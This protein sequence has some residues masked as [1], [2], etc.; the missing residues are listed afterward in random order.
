MLGVWLENE[1]VRVRSDLPD[2]EPS[3][4][5]ALIR[6][7]RAGICGTD[8]ALARGYRPGRGRVPGHEFVGVVA[9]G[10]PEWIAARVVGEINVTCR[11]LAHGAPPC[12]ECASGRRTH[13]RR[14]AAVGIYG[15]DGAFAER[16]V[17]PLANLHRVP[18]SI[19]DDEATFVEPLAAALRVRE[20]VALDRDTRVVV[21][22]PGRLGIL[23]ARALAPTGTPVTAVGRSRPGVERARIAGLR[24][25][26]ADAAESAAFDV[27]IECSGDPDG[28]STAR[29]LVRPGGTIVLKSTPAD[30]VTLGLGSTVVD[31][32]TIVGSRCGPF[33][34]AIQALAQGVVAVADLVDDRFPLASAP[35][36]FERAGEPGVAKVLL[37]P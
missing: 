29:R 20:Q 7:L 32:I 6:V 27:A 17:L 22:G 26:T 31:E 35:E 28:L 10:P 5:E 33:P 13:C 25:I 9:A 15:W 21:V 11:S 8:L 3:E 2:P 23:V 14:R 34:T 19:D 24:V 18:D 37:V 36:A 12:P 30:D 4:G 16:L 1:R